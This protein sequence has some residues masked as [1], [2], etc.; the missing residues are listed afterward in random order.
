MKKTLLV[1]SLIFFQSAFCQLIEKVNSP[2]KNESLDSN[3]PYFIISPKSFYGTFS[4][5]LNLEQL[6]EIKII[7]TDLNN[8]TLIEKKLGKL[9]KYFSK[10]SMEDF[11]TGKY[12]FYV[13]NEKSEV[14]FQTEI[15]N[16]QNN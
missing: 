12:I 16:L 2:I 9:K 5:Q 15:E 7:I 1:L 4:V 6:E 3:K 11:A 10:M 8:N 13:K 14:L